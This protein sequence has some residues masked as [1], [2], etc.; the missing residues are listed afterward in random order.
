MFFF[1]YF[2]DHRKETLFNPY[3]L[4]FACHVTIIRCF[5]KFI[6]VLQKY[7]DLFVFQW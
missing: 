7:I 3:A 2:I 6:N 4:L 5:S 1:S